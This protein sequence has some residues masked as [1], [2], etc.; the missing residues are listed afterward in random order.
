MCTV[1]WEYGG[2]VARVAWLYVAYCLL[3]ALLLYNLLVCSQCFIPPPCSEYSLNRI[4]FLYPDLLFAYFPLTMPTC[5]KILLVAQFIIIETLS[6][7]LL[8]K[9]STKAVQLK[10]SGK[11][12][13]HNIWIIS[14]NI[15]IIHC[16]SAM[17]KL[18][19]SITK[20]VADDSGRVV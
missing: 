14:S 16:N 11:L 3:P 7:I 1:L 19:H 17:R 12:S 15:R 18:Y 20:F 10:S 2:H 13:P 6:H 8:N 4:I 5:Y 9:L